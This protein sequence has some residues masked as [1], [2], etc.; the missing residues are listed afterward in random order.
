MNEF[1]SKI[2]ENKKSKAMNALKSIPKQ[3]QP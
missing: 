1:Y 2:D 3:H